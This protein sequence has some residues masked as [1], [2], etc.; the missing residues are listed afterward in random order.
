LRS[1]VTNDAHRDGIDDA[2][3]AGAWDESL[4]PL[5]LILARER[6]AISSQQ[7]YALAALCVPV[8]LPV[9]DLHVSAS[10]AG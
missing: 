7:R 6:V 3:N 5:V 4:E 10:A 2:L 8:D 1:Y 9:P